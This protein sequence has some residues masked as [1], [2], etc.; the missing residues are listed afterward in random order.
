MIVLM[1]KTVEVVD[2]RNKALLGIKGEVVDET[3]SLIVLDTGKK[4]LK[5]QVKIQVDGQMVHGENLVG[6][7]HERLKK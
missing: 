7:L 4:L 3:R 2:A 5:A 6:R 1:G